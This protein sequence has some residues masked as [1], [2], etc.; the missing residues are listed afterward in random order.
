MD[1]TRRVSTYP[2][3]KRHGTFLDEYKCKV[4]G[5]RP[6]LP[7]SRESVRSCGLGGP[8]MG[9]G[10]IRE[11]ADQAGG[12]LRPVPQIVYSSNAS[13]PRFHRD[14]QPDTCVALLCTFASVSSRFVP[15]SFILL[16]CLCRDAAA[17]DRCSYP[18]R[19]WW[20]PRQ[21]LGWRFP[22]TLR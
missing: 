16:G 19:H 2:E 14:M 4:D 7:F 6:R 5:R 22:S 3:S 1:R 18:W 11:P 12:H 20:A 15:Q 9:E 13:T 21:G 17:H 8:S 10:L